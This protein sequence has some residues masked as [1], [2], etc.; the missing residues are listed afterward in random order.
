MIKIKK[1]YGE[2]V[3]YYKVYYLNDIIH[4]ENGPAYIWYYENGNID[5]QYC[6]I[7]G[8]MT[9][10]NDNTPAYQEYTNNGLLQKIRHYLNGRVHK[11]IPPQLLDIMKMV[12]LSLK[13]IIII[14]LI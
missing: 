13:N 11:K 14:R 7:N 12:I 2:R 3:L 6:Y 1:Q 10:I 5:I 8:I 4:R 9:D